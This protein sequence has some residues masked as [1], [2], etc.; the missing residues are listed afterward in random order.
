MERS[1]LS[2]CPYLGSLFSQLHVWRKRAHNGRVLDCEGRVFCSAISRWIDT[3]EDQHYQI[4]NR[5]QIAA[6]A[7][8]LKMIE[9]APAGPCEKEI[10]QR[11][12]LDQFAGYREA[13]WILINI[14]SNIGM[15]HHSYLLLDQADGKLRMLPWD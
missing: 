11:V 15:P 12:D 10:G 9:T 13:T 2:G 4:K 5:S 7:S 6:F 3:R 14:D 1:V 8:L